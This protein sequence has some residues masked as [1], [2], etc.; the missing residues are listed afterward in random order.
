LIYDSAALSF[1]GGYGTPG[2]SITF[3]LYGPSD[4]TYSTPL[5]E[6]VVAVSGAGTYSTP[7]GFDPS[8]TGFGVYTWIATYSGDNFY[9]LSA[10]TDSED[11]DEK[12]DLSMYPGLSMFQASDASQ[13]FFVRT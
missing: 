8:A 10:F 11:A 12:I 2:G 1:S 6:Q 5:D 4:P 7:V 3:R 13:I 9:A